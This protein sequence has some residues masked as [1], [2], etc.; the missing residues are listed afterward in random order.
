[1]R[2]PA[3]TLAPGAYF[4]RLVADPH[5]LRAVRFEA[6]GTWAEGQ[7]AEPNDK[8]DQANRVDFGSPL[9]GRLNSRA[10]ADYFSFALD[11]EYTERRLVLE[12]TADKPNQK[13]QT[14]LLDSDGDRMQCRSGRGAVRHDGLMLDPGRYILA[15]DKGRKDT[16]YT[17]TLDSDGPHEPGLEGEPNDALRLA[18]GFPAKHRIKGQLGPDDQDFYRVMVDVEPQLWRFQ[19]IGEG[20]QEVAYYDGAGKRVQ[21][22]R[23]KGNQRRVRLDNVFL[24]PGTHY[25]SV[26]GNKEG[27]YT[28]LARLLG[29]PDPNAER[30][31]NDDSSRSHRLAVDQTRTGT[32]A[33]PGDQDYYRFFI[34]N[35]DHLRL[36]IRPPAD[37]IVKA[38]LSWYGAKLGRNHPGKPGETISLSGVFPPGDYEL[39]LQPK[40]PSDAEYQLQLERLPRFSCPADCEPNGMG[41]LH[42]AAPVP[43]SL[44]LEGRSGDWRDTDVFALPELSAPG[45]LT[46]HSTKPV[47][48]L[49]LATGGPDEQDLEFDDQT[50]SYAAQ[51]PAGGPHY[52]IV[53]S[54]RQD[55]RLELEL[56]AASGIEPV[57]EALPVALELELDTGAVAA[58]R[59]EG[60]RV[61]GTLKIRNNS[62]TK[63]KAEI[64]TATSDYRWQVAPGSKPIAVDAGATLDMP[65]DVLVPPD[66]WAD[67]P[68]T[69]S[70][71]ARGAGSV[72]AE[73]AQTVQVERN[74][75][76]VGSRPG[77]QIPEALRG[78]FNIAW[79]P[80]G[81][82]W[83][84]EP[85]DVVKLENLRDGVVFAGLRTACCGSPYGWEDDY[86]PELTLAL[87]G[88][89]PMPVAGMALNHFGS[90]KAVSNIRRATLLLST[91]GVKY[92]PVLA[93]ETLPVRTEQYF[94][95]EEP[96]MASFARLRVD[97]TFS[98]PRGK[99]GLSL[100]E[101]KLILAPGYD[102]TRGSEFN[103]ADPAWGGHLVHDKPP[104]FY[105][106]RN[107]LDEQKEGTRAAADSDDT[108][109]YVIGFHHNRTAQISRIEWVYA[110][111]VEASHRF[112][113][114][115]IAASLESPVGPW[116]PLGEF[117]LSDSEPLSTLELDAPAW[118]RFIRLSAARKPQ[119]PPSWGP[120]VIRIF[121]RSTGDDYR[122]IVS[123]WGQA[124]RRAYYEAQMEN[125]TASEL[126]AAANRSRAEAAPLAPGDAVSGRVALAQYEHWY[127]VSVPEEQNTLTVTLSGEP[128]VR[129]VVELQDSS[130]DLVPMQRVDR[131]ESARH[132]FEVVVEPGSEVFL[133]V[134]EPPRN[135]VFSWDT[136]A[137]VN[138]YLPLIYKSLAAFSSQ[139]IPGQEAVNLVPFGRGPL[140]ED[141][142]GEP[143]VLQTIL[144]E[145]PRSESSSAAEKTLK[146][147]AEALAPLP[148]TKSV[149]LITDADTTVDGTMWDAM[150]EVRPRVF[151]VQVAGTKAM[152]QDL[153]QDWTDV[154]GGHY[155][156]LFY[157]GE[158]EVAFDRAST[159]MRRPAPYT[160][161]VEAEFREA[162]GPGQLRVVSGDAEQAR[163]T[164]GAIE[165]I[166]D[167]SGSMLQRLEGRR[168][169]A[170]AREVLTEAVTE[171]LPPGTRVA[172]RVF[173]QKEP[174][175]CRT[176]LEIPLGPLDP[177]AARKV[178]A[179]IQAKNL[180]RTPIA[181]SLAHV[182]S[183][184]VDAE[185]NK[186]VVL[187]TDGEETCDGDPAAVIRDLQDKGIGVHLN[188]VGFAV[189]DPELEST[190]Q[191]WA[192]LGGG[193]YFQATDPE[194]LSR[195]LEDALRVP[196]SV[197]DGSGEPV[198]QGTV[199]GEPLELPAGVYKV[200][201]QGGQARVFEQ[202]EI[203]SGEQ[204]SLEVAP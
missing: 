62:E 176:D 86:R 158:M 104:E 142:H 70:V 202:V 103:L 93:F 73:T 92:E 78:G 118:A 192:E 100:G 189:D 31:P 163:A 132:V 69:I 153:F 148:G 124:S 39:A 77:W 179:D 191:D 164:A 197:F 107:V 55:Y 27:K 133:R 149:V 199:D 151:G 134:Y 177:E 34:A 49:Q 7:E 152:H 155:K 203:P 50:A 139:V 167:A 76:P 52:L 115:S 87:P 44:V 186:T 185:G 113:R 23:T 145:Y 98:L 2:M 51:I 102:P 170:I 127:R 1:M 159:L 41:D 188:I 173:G 184:L 14:C 66:A 60:Q 15:V 160:L 183:D 141:W 120:D 20:I 18:T 35:H 5:T 24:L 61:G 48:S 4:L 204:V 140:L 144:N 143:Y 38:E 154:N 128:T 169:I 166:L 54:R 19:V 112:D 82:E 187:V 165:L 198:A 72:T 193:R 29:Q 116:Q 157:E 150:R 172:L 89:E 196:F 40:K 21:R 33:D 190:F 125:D 30:E 80:F 63:L 114:V 126:A 101:W 201:V 90:P 130:G 99:R 109:D 97:E 64:E 110:D 168:R 12:T 81:A 3:L 28:L 180:A 137:S 37:G 136:S 95:L 53:D 175:A 85:S 58:Y 106:P 43:P 56:P 138:A 22:I 195:A 91:D 94:A 68:V 111:D 57:T 156:Q 71:A 108:Q 129:T 146:K 59:A 174:N 9:K 65:L 182:E 88:D 42:R 122:S 47:G 178:I 105:K 46:I 135:V 75:P 45:V 147:S 36:S 32:L 84:D 194:G 162:P 26:A 200:A 83:R 74:I 10:D 67:H 96:V 17:V 181:D 6:A 119:A 171:H 131:G 79:A 11:A 123:E 8:W 117:A 161:Q 121:E 16:D 25:L 13:L